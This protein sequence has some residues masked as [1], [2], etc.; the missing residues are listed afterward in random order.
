MAGVRMRLVR[1]RDIS[2]T[3]F[4]D[5]GDAVARGLCSSLVTVDEGWV[6]V[7]VVEMVV[8]AADRAV[9]PGDVEQ[10]ARTTSANKSGI[11]SR[12]D[13]IGEKYQCSTQGSAAAVLWCRRPGGREVGA[14]IG[15]EERGERAP[16]R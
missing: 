12:Q 14:T 8:L 10:L 13:P 16:G 2:D 4:R 3:F 7:V 5:Y 11:V 6:D 9:D 1:S 15:G